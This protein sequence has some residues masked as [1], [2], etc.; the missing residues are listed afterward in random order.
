M[1]TIYKT[2]RT[3]NTKFYNQIKDLTH[4]E[5]SC[6]QLILLGLGWDCLFS[7]ITHFMIL[8]LTD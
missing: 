2:K 6:W 8:G 3:K 4:L 1:K 7:F 5:M